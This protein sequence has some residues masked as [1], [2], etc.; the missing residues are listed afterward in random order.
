MGHRLNHATNELRVDAPVIIVGG[1]P[2]GLALAL[3]LAR[4][5]AR[6]IVLERNPEPV[7]ESRAA[8]IWPRTQEILRDWGAYAPLR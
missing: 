4:Y 5:G 2:V 8:V 7:R 6:S 3:G 1:G